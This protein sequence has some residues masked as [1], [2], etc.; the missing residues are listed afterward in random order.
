MTKRSSSIPSPGTIDNNWPHQVALAQDLCYAENYNLIRSF[1]EANGLDYQTRS[2]QAIWP[3]R[4]YLDIRLHCFIDRAS[5]EL[6]QAHFGG[7]FFDPKRD[8]EGGTLRGSWRREGVWT[9]VLE[10][11]PLKIPQFL[12]D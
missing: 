9:R 7:E 3:D 11:G 1:C 4:R 6:F 12:R 10:S 8:R 5:A 2:V